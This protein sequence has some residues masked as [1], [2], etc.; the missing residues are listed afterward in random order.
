MQQ[1]VGYYPDLKAAH[2]HNDRHRPRKAAAREGDL[3]RAKASQCH[4]YCGDIWQNNINAHARVTRG[5]IVIVPMQALR[6]VPLTDVR[7]RS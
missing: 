4:R 7:N 6:G 1:D 5:V 3:R 2:H